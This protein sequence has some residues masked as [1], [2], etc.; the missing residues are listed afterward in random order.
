MSYRLKPSAFESAKP[1]IDRINQ[2]SWIW[3]G[4]QTLHGLCCVKAW[5]ETENWIAQLTPWL[6]LASK[7]RET[8]EYIILEFE[9][10]V[11]LE[12]ATLGRLLPLKAING[13]LSSFPFTLLNQKNN[14]QQKIENS[15]LLV[16]EGERHIIPLTDFHSVDVMSW[17]SFETLFAVESSPLPVKEAEP[18]FN[19]V[20]QSK[21]QIDENAYLAGIEDIAKRVEPRKSSLFK[22]LITP[23]MFLISNFARLLIWGFI[24]VVSIIV[25]GTLSQSNHVI[26]WPDL[27]TAIVGFF[28]AYHLLM[29]VLKAISPLGPV[30]GPS[31]SSRSS[32][33]SSGSG[34]LPQKP[35]QYRPNILKRAMGWLVWNSALGTGLHR[36]YGQ[37]IGE[38]EELFAKGKIDEALRKALPLGN[39]N[40]E[41]EFKKKSFGNFPLS[42]PEIRQNLF[43]QHTVQAQNSHDILSGDAHYALQQMYRQQVQELIKNEDYERAAFIS[44]ELLND[45]AAAVEIFERKGD[46][47][48]AAKLAQGRKLP[49]ETF[50]PLWYKA[51]EKQKALHLAA[52]YDVFAALYNSVPKEDPFFKDLVTAWSHRL[53]ALNNYLKALELTEKI[54]SLQE[55][56]QK[57]ISEALVIHPNDPTLLARALKCLKEEHEQQ[58]ADLLND[59]LQKE[60][61]ESRSSQIELAEQLAS[62]TFEKVGVQENFSSERLPLLA[63]PLLRKLISDEAQYGTNHKRKKACLNLS[64]AGKQQALRVDLRR[65]NQINK[66]KKPEPQR[67]VK[68]KPVTDQT[69][70]NTLIMIDENRLLIA[71]KSGALHL[72]NRNG[73]VLWS[74]HIHNIAGLV[75]I[76]SSNTI[77][78]IR[79]E[80]E[81]RALSLLKLNEGTHK[82]IGFYDIQNFHS[83]ASDFGWLVFLNNKVCMIDIGSLIKAAEQSDG[84]LE[85][86]WSVPVSEPGSLLCF[87][88]TH[89]EVSFLFERLENN[90]LELWA[91]NKATLEVS[92]SFLVEK[93]EYLK[94]SDTIGWLGNGSFCTFSKTS[95]KLEK[96]WLTKTKYSLET[97]R[98]LISTQETPSL[99]GKIVGSFP[100]NANSLIWG[101]EQYSASRATSVPTT[102]QNH[103]INSLIWKATLWGN[104]A[105]LFRFEFPEANHISTHLLKDHMIAAISDDH[106]RIITIDFNSDQILYRND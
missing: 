47:K 41:D 82:D 62:K 71:Y 70:I 49:P 55:E 38:I 9:K 20:F 15:L 99:K 1:L 104:Q 22:K 54:E 96:H 37:R 101:V 30:G 68:L 64:I 21:I 69:P 103:E 57:W 76:G 84:Q 88:E 10:P 51:G 105:K 19:P 39:N 11:N 97:E 3:Q 91:L 46:F 17:W 65:L 66:I 56:R 33:G 26:S 74:D 85:H 18:P 8:K 40:S 6:D 106:G 50:I 34:A 23:I 5:C 36:K 75:P 7:V 81:G 13:S 28:I 87:S 52:Q 86:H 78:V 83:E 29:L 60:D 44:A 93:S 80:I 48:T 63:L 77:I 32:S 16:R 45:P 90:L 53:L 42:G 4:Q 92:C 35:L 98:K 102:N 31:H 59:F 67:Q 25:L 72:I 73:R 43:I 100:L 58:L 14:T 2:K 27:I 12:C 79:D 61:P 24:V 94:N 95:S 89:S